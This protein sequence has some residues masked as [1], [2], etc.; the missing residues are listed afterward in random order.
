MRVTSTMPPCPGGSSSR[1][2]RGG[3]KTWRTRSLAAW[4]PSTKKFLADAATAFKDTDAKLAEEIG[5]PTPE[6]NKDIKN[7]DAYKKLM[8]RDKSKDT[9]Q[10]GSFRKLDEQSRK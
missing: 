8:E 4:Y 1:A 6:T 3:C 2:A 10:E 5:D 9:L 7:S